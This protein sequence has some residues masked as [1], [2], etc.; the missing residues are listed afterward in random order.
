MDRI[1][2]SGRFSLHI[3]RRKSRSRSKSPSPHNRENKTFDDTLTSL[4]SLTSFNRTGDFADTQGT[5][6]TRAM[7][8][9]IKLR[10]VQPPKKKQQHKII[11]LNSRLKTAGRKIIKK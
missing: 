8:P 6:N 3:S 11:D 5:L 7:T 10:P 9:E 4:D 2:E 1:V